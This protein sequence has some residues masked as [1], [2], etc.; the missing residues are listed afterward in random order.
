MSL[1]MRLAV[2]AMTIAVVAGAGLAIADRAKAEGVYDGVYIGV[3][4]GYVFGQ[5]EFNAPSAS[6][7]VSEDGKA[8]LEGGMVGGL[9]GY[10]HSFGNG[11]VVGVVGDLSWLGA[12][13]DVSNA[14]S[15]SNLDLSVDWLGTV[16]G[17]LGFEVGD[18]LIYGTGGVAF[19]GIDSS[20]RIDGS[21]EVGSDTGTQVGW[22]LGV[23]ANYMLNE[24]IMLGI[25]YLYVDLGEAGL[26][27]G[28]A[29]TSDVD[30]HM[31]VIRGSVGFK[32]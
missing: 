19:G 28:A 12:E 24:N 13:G 16:R 32:F 2:G 23:G 9:V 4:G 11:L 6:P 10:D 14:S 31:N 30:V 29:G 27:Y 5:G 15:V 1:K 18:A 26:D 7:L 17:R 21:G 3:T 22:T 20:I 8:D 25:E